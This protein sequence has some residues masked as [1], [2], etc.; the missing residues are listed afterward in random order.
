MWTIRALTIIV[1]G[2]GL[3]GSA[4]AAEVGQQTQAQQLVG[5]WEQ[6]EANS[7]REPKRTM[8]FQANGSIMQGR[9]VA[10][11]SFEPDGRLK[12]VQGGSHDPAFATIEFA[13]QGNTMLFRHDRS[14]IQEHWIRK[15]AGRK[16]AADEVDDKKM[17]ELL[18]GRWRPVNARNG[19]TT[20]EFS[21]DGKMKISQLI[22]GTWSLG[23]GG[24]LQTSV[25]DSGNGNAKTDL[26][27]VRFSQDGKV[28]VFKVPTDKGGE[29][30]FQRLLTQPSVE[31]QREL[32]AGRWYLS[33]PY[34]TIPC[35]EFVTGGTIRAEGKEAGTWSVEPDG[36]LKLEIAENGR[37]R[38]TKKFLTEWEEK[39]NVMILSTAE[40]GQQYPIPCLRLAARLEPEQTGKALA[41]SWWPARYSMRDG[42]YSRFEFCPD[43]TLKQAGQKTGAWEVRPGN[44][45]HYSVVSPGRD[46]KPESRTCQVEFSADM[47]TAVFIMADT[48][49]GGPKVGFLHCRLVPKDDLKKM[50]AMLVGQWQSKLRGTPVPGLQ[51]SADGKMKLYG[52]TGS[53]SLEPDGRLKTVLA[54]PGQKDSVTE[55]AFLELIQDGSGLIFRAASP[56]GIQGIALESFSR[57]ETADSMPYPAEAAPVPE[58]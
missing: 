52:A 20:M 34:S 7:P 9:H 36:I 42:D 12:I 6:A 35:L 13:D 16:P 40:R 44:M 29:P 49:M 58:R 50:S 31:K 30:R 39:F 3:G 32:L 26:I 46:Q 10:I 37:P 22:P 38:Q 11:W 17:A 54:R 27:P 48:Q 14:N 15:S 23:H 56:D 28:L 55:Y 45:L 47:N 2:I 57:D 43:G 5:E 4:L 18:V 41:G 19:R 8:E 51:F 25:D 33:I 53:W 1:L 24:I 21:A